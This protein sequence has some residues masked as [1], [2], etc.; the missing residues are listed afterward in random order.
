MSGTRE[1]A[2]PYFRRARVD[3][4]FDGH[5]RGVQMVLMI[6]ALDLGD[7]AA[8]RPKRIGSYAPYAVDTLFGACGA[9]RIAALTAIRSETADGLAGP[10]GGPSL[11]ITDLRIEDQTVAF[12]V[13]I[14]PAE[15]TGYGMMEVYNAAGDRLSGTDLG[16]FTSG[17]VWNLPLDPGGEL[18]DGDFAAWVK[19][20]AEDPYHAV[21]FDEKGISFLVGRGRI[22]PSRE[23]APPVG[24]RRHI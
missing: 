20:N 22:F 21:G 14:D 9:A 1:L 23:F 16:A 7:A 24:V 6:W 10:M 8:Q 19:V 3:E 13:S 11:K 18:A 4:A 12:G 2:A 15:I 5:H 17:Q